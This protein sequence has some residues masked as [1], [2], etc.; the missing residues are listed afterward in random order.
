MI[1]YFAPLLCL[2]PSAWAHDGHGAHGVHSHATDAWGL[3]VGLALAV[4]LAVW[5]R[6]RK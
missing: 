3:V 6:G 4:S 2:V 1:K 5:L